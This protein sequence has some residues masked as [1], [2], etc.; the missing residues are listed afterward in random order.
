MEQNKRIPVVLN[1]STDPLVKAIIENY[2]IWAD[3]VPWEKTNNY[4][5]HT[6]RLFDTVPVYLAYAS[7][8]ISIRD[9]ELS[10]TEGG[11]TIPAKGGDRVSVAIEWKDLKRF[12]KHIVKRLT[13]SSLTR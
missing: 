6:S 13:N 4:T 9:M 3:L 7:D 5:S 12:K 11:K 1:T 2:R 10:I 8:L